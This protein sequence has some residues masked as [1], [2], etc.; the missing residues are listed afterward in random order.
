MS[1]VGEF[2]SKKSPIVYPT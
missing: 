2:V 1:A